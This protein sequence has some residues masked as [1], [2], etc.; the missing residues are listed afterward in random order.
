M[1]TIV[2]T[3]PRAIGGKGEISGK[4]EVTPEEL[5]S[6][7]D[8]AHYELIDG[9]LKERNVSYLS[10]LVASQII[11]QL[12]NHVDAK[13]LGS[14]L[15]P[16]FGYRCF[17]WKPRR[18]R[19]ADVSFIRTERLTDEVLSA[20]DCPI[21]PDL[22]VEVVSPNDSVPELNL[23]I[24]EYLRAGVK[25]VWVVDPEIRTLDIYR[26]D[27]TTQRLRENDQLTGEDVVPGFSCQVAL[28]LPNVV[29]AAAENSPVA[30]APPGG[31]P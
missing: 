10:S 26:S 2:E 22:A 15:P 24:E 11:R 21:P 16:D 5:L 20:G 1:S 6:M 25:L 9:E 3:L 29:P 14:V 31:S 23:K 12:G 30:A 8:S 28:L 18:V 4:V 13:R 17:A 27:G 19:R 7:P